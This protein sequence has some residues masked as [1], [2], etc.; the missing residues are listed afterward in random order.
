MIC[1]EGHLLKNEKT[2]LSIAMNRI[3]TMRRIVLTG[4]PLQNNLKEYWC[5]VQFIK[6][7]LLG[8]YK[9]YMNRFVN[10]ITNGQYTD[11]TQHDTILMRKRSH[12]LHK[13]LDGVVQRRDYA[14]LEPYLPTK[15][16]FVLFVKL[17]DT[18]IKL[19]KY[20][21]EKLAKKNDGS[22]RTSFLFTDF[23]QLQRI[24]THPRVLADKTKEKK[25]KWDDEDDESEG[26]LKD[27]INDDEDSASKSSSNNSSSNES[28]VSSESVKKKKKGRTRV[29]RAVAAQSK[30]DF[31]YLFV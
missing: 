15:H 1:D 12:V 26:S 3:K 31:F 25:E 20:Y 19:Y 7:N 4:T 29:T 16:E 10:P 28:D 27:F 2:H 17:S 6:P 18:Q 9:E 13:L 8:T 14:V 5:M 21:M 30:S 11:S 24:C 22:N 23:Q